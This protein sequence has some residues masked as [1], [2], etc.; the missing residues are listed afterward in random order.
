[1]AFYPKKA[2]ELVC[3]QIN[4]DNPNLPTP[5]T[6]DNVVLLSGPFTTNLGSS[7][8]NTRAIFNGVAGKGNIG[9]REVFYDRI[10]L[11]ALFSGL[12]ATFTV[13]IPNNAKTVA[14]IL[15]SIN[16][17]FGITL[18]ATDV[19]NPTNPIGL[20]ATATTITL[21]AS[22]T[23]L[24]FTGSFTFTYV[25]AAAGYY[26]NS[27]PGSKYMRFGDMSLGYFGTVTQSELVT[28][29]GLYNEVFGGKTTQAIPVVDLNLYWLKFALDGKVVYFPNRAPINYS[30]W[31]ELDGLGAV[32]ANRKYPYAVQNDNGDYTLVQMRLPRLTKADPADAAYRGDPD[33]EITRLFNKI[34]ALRYGTAEWDNLATF[35]VS[36]QLLYLNRST[37]GG[38][39]YTRAW[40]NTANFDATNTLVL[41][42]DKVNWRPLL[43]LADAKDYVM[44]MRAVNGVRFAALTKPG[45]SYVREPDPLQLTR[46]R[47]VQGTLYSSVRKPWL[48]PIASAPVTA[49]TNLAVTRA[50]K[51]AHPTV[52]VSFPVLVD[53]A[54]TDGE[55]TGF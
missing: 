42:T 27:G 46:M 47:D 31:N 22:A 54:T 11:A 43:V 52:S 39:P 7:G 40:T 50:L 55:L 36:E 33:S 48:N 2:L 12:P 18:G 26:P 23:C 1:M 38:V 53:L 35:N 19:T 5:F 8:R 6:A 13:T 3:A 29:S 15:P 9:K 10:N 28:N 45:L 44:P 34:H 24:S 20:G 30:N 16:D 37:Y 4:R 32:Y 14:D 17:T 41:L 25:R 21:T 51:P 49:V